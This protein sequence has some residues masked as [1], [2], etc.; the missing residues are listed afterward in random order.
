METALLGTYVNE[1]RKCIMYLYNFIRLKGTKPKRWIYNSKNCA[2]LEWVNESSSP[3]GR[4]KH[5]HRERLD[6][7]RD[8]SRSANRMSPSSVKI[9]PMENREYLRDIEKTQKWKNEIGRI[10]GYASCL[11]VVDVEYF[12]YDLLLSRKK[13]RQLNYEPFFRAYTAGNNMNHIDDLKQR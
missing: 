4:P 12:E 1:I 3:N 2:S 6:N 8:L 13:L 5:R 7:S 10:V 9:G 11:E